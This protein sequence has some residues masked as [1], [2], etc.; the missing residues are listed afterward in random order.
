MIEQYQYE[1]VSNITLMDDE[2]HVYNTFTT[3][4]ADAE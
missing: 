2:L 4:N 3:P 1:W